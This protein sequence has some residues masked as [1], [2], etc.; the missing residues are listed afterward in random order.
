MLRIGSFANSKM[1]LQVAFECCDS[2]IWRSIAQF[3][4]VDCCATIEGMTANQIRK[5]RSGIQ[6]VAFR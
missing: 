2:I 1:R 4:N 3:E 5:P 6:T